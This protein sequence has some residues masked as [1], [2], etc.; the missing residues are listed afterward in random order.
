MAQYF[1]LQRRK[2]SFKE[3][4]YESVSA[5]QA[6]WQAQNP[7][8][9]IPVPSLCYSSPLNRCQPLANLGTSLAKLCP[10]PACTRD[11][12]AEP[13]SARHC[14]RPH[15]NGIP[16]PPDLTGYSWDKHRTKASIVM[17]FQAAHP[18]K[19]QLQPEAALLCVHCKAAPLI[20]EVFS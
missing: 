9:L 14:W 3:K 13:S 19:V 4:K 2:F 15:S 7:F 1:S 18:I 20:N 11:S 5:A 16:E 8:I 6:P 12:K 17:F 10:S